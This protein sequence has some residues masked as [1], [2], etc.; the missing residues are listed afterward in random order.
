MDDPGASPK[1][2]ETGPHC[3]SVST[4]DKSNSTWKEEPK[5][6]RGLRSTE[7]H[8]RVFPGEKTKA[9]ATHMGFPGLGPSPV[10]GTHSPDSSLT[11]QRCRDP[12]GW[13][14]EC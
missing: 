8:P 11:P 3:G 10:L 4:A 2:N 14:S 12:A 1:A 6:E 7:N 5:P 13:L 9:V